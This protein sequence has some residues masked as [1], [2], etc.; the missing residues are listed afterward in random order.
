MIIPDSD[1]KI[2]LDRRSIV[3]QRNENESIENFL[4]RGVE[5]LAASL[6]E[7]GKQKHEWMVVRPSQMAKERAI[8]IIKKI[9]WDGL[10]EPLFGATL[11]QGFAIE[12]KM[13]DRELE[14]EIDAEGLLEYFMVRND[15][16]LED[17]EE[18]TFTL[19]DG[20]LVRRIAW[21]MGDPKT[22]ALLE[23][24]RLMKFPEGESSFSPSRPK[25]ATMMFARAVVEG[26]NWEGMIIPVVSAGAD[27]SIHFKWRMPSKRELQ[28]FIFPDGIEYLT[29]DSGGVV[30]EGEFALGEMIAWLKG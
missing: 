9:N 19:E 11:N 8:A 2:S 28:M 4:L 6:P 24:D 23:L 1:F 3:M 14:I 22:H 27:G 26:I 10:A 15:R 30:S 29:A 13:S 5:H 18:G 16:N 20:T 21:L 25:P 12:W 17:T 7:P